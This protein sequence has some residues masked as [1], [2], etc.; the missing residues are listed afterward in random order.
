[1]AAAA[2]WASDEFA[3]AAGETTQDVGL[4]LTTQPKAVGVSSS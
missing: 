2:K 3:E 4:T 1:M